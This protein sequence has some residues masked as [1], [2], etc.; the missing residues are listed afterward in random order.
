MVIDEETPPRL[1][2]RVL[3]VGSADDPSLLRL[4]ISKGK[5]GHYVALSHCW[6][7]PEKRPLRIMTTNI[8]DHI[9]AISMSSL[10]KTFQDAVEVT[11]AIGLRYLWIDSLCII[12][13]DRDDWFRES[14]EMGLVY[15]YARITIAASHAHDGTEGLFLRRP[16][17]PPSIEIPYINSAGEEHGSMFIQSRGNSSYTD[18]WSPDF[19]PLS[20]R[21][22]ITQEWLLARRTVFFTR[23][24]LIWS[25]GE[26]EGDLETHRLVR[27]RHMRGLKVGSD[28]DW[29]SIVEHYSARLLTY[30]TDKLVA[31]QGIANELR[32][33]YPERVYAQGLW[34]NDLPRHLLWRGEV[35]NLTRTPPKL[36]IPSWSW[37]S[38]MGS[39]TLTTVL[40]P[41]FDA[42]S[43]NQC[44][45][46]N[47]LGD[48]RTLSLE[49]K[50]KKVGISK[51]SF[52]P[53]LGKDF[54]EVI[55]YQPETKEYLDIE[56][57][58]DIWLK[59]TMNRHY[60]T[61]PAG[62]HSFIFDFIDRAQV[63]QVIGCAHMDMATNPKEPVFAAL[64][65]SSDSV[66]QG[67]EEY[68]ELPSEHILILEKVGTEEGGVRQFERIGEGEITRCGAAS[69]FEGA[70]MET[71]QIV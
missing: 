51:H 50:I 39:V 21:A 65:M 25:C 58:Q 61:T 16:D 53:I 44:G 10:P 64:L 47:L 27:Q 24:R 46:I 60:W 1:P 56:W 29:G 35:R 17:P 40:T 71:I 22:W 31:L 41:D 7:P 18:T 19:G 67:G 11:R 33:K 12:Q 30:A 62:S 9:K 55:L 38:K 37:A 49:A 54:S 59:G 68:G 4:K 15:Q 32:K 45:R 5:C 2:T 43:S 8:Q 48:G 28:D 26:L 23:S 34:V 20:K 13:D 14:Q 57:I 36:N 52:R 42:G 70:E 6:G 63:G 3:E 69:F 66:S